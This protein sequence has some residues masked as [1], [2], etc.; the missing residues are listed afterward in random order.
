MMLTITD[1]TRAMIT[2]TANNFG[3]RLGGRTRSSSVL[4]ASS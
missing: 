2:T 3:Q 1:P 4:I